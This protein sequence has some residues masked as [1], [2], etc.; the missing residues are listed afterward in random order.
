MRFLFYI[1]YYIYYNNTSFIHTHKTQL[2]KKK[3]IKWPQAGKVINE[4][5]CDISDI[6]A[7]SRE[8]KLIIQLL[9]CLP[10]EI[11]ARRG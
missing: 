2:I 10:S 11:P 3:N 9:D 1:I 5:Y 7:S 6:Y 4:R 8:C